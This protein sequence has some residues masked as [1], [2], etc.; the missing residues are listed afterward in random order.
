[1]CFSFLPWQGKL[2]VLA[3]GGGSAGGCRKFLQTFPPWC[4]CPNPHSGI[5]PH[6]NSV[7]GLGEALAEDVFWLR[8]KDYLHL[9]LPCLTIY[10][11]LQAKVMCLLIAV[12]YH[13]Q[14]LSSSNPPFPPLECAFRAK[15]KLLPVLQRRT[16]ADQ[17]GGQEG[18]PGF[19]VLQRHQH[20]AFVL[21][22]LWSHLNWDVRGGKVKEATYFNG[23]ALAWESGDLG[24]SADSA[25]H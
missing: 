7:R 13:I 8:L 21:K 25:F 4:P 1:M 22:G 12:D 19:W 14:E 6:Q 18:G 10:L 23:K 5:Q 9:P 2:W 3:E 17:S 20:W 16:W 15:M 24:S 11:P